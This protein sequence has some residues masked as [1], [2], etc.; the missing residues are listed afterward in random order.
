MVGVAGRR[1]LA[2]L[3]Y[4]LGENFDQYLTQATKRALQGGFGQASSAEKRAKV[5]RRKSLQGRRVSFAPDDQL[6]TIQLFQRDCD[7]PSERRLGGNQGEADPPATSIDVAEL[8]TPPAGLRQGDGAGSPMELTLSSPMAPA[9]YEQHAES[10][11]A[12]TGSSPGQDVSM[13]LT[14]GA[15]AAWRGAGQQH[16]ADLQTSG[17]V[18]AQSTFGIGPQASTN[19]GMQPSGDVS[20]ELTS[21]TGASLPAGLEEMTGQGL[22]T[23]GFTGVLA[24]GRHP[25]WG[26]QTE[27]TAMQPAMA[28]DG[29]P[30]GQVGKWGFAPG[31]DD[32]MEMNLEGKGRDLMGDT[33]FGHVFGGYEST[34]NTMG[35]R[36]SSQ[37]FIPAT[38]QPAQSATHPAAVALTPPA[39]H[40]SAHSALP[41]PGHSTHSAATSSPN[42][43]AQSRSAA[44]HSN[45]SAAGSS[46]PSAMAPSAG[47][48]TCSR[49]AWAAG[50]DE[51]QNA[52]F[53][54]GCGRPRD[55]IGAMMQQ[56]DPGRDQENV[57]GWLVD[58]PEGAAG[59]ASLIVL[60]LKSGPGTPFKERQPASL[61]DVD[62]A[63]YPSPKT[64]ADWFETPQGTA[65]PPSHPCSQTRSQSRYTLSGH[66]TCPTPRAITLQDFLQ[67]VDVQLLDHVLRGPSLAP[68]NAAL[69][70]PPRHWRYPLSHHISAPECWK[71]MCIT[72]PRM[73][74]L[75]ESCGIL[76]AEIDSKRA[77]LAQKEAD[78]ART[79][80]S[81]FL[82]LQRGSREQVETLKKCA[83]VLKRSCRKQTEGSWKRWR[84][85]LEQ[86]RQMSLQENMRTLQ[87]DA[88][89]LQVSMS[90]QQEVGARLETY[91]AESEA[92]LQAAKARKE[93]EAG[94]QARH[95]M[96]EVDILANCLGWRPET[97]SRQ[98]VGSSQQGPLE[99]PPQGFKLCFSPHLSLCVRFEAVE[100]LEAA[101]M[102]IRG[103]LLWTDSGSPSLGKALLAS[104]MGHPLAPSTKGDSSS[105]S[106]VAHSSLGAPTQ[107]LAAFELTG[108]CAPT[109]LAEK[110]REL[111]SQIQQARAVARDA[112]EL[113][114][115]VPRQYQLS[116]FAAWHGVWTKDRGPIQP[117]GSFERDQALC[118][119]PPAAG[120]AAMGVA[121]PPA[122]S[123]VGHPSPGAGPSDALQSPDAAA[124]NVFSNPLYSVA[125]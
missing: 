113:M 8:G 4:S 114:L 46:P 21:A 119:R 15:P 7:S 115:A 13:D 80:P 12:R 34:T 106:G 27:H 124:L 30:D 11:I 65:A 47:E 81:V 44:A 49:A 60:V 52:A 51:G 1:H 54:H 110:V 73:A 103:E 120:T 100:S 74:V 32:T 121:T 5:E 125:R 42:I 28:M 55:S 102:C 122:A 24:G 69:D 50:T 36:R 94:R 76:D 95:K 10:R 85:G 58:G 6:R 66:R 99:G 108:K 89:F 19:R 79:N 84:T 37:M 117:D 41:L 96:E 53:D 45:Y 67:G 64:L 56:Q 86:R 77:G 48:G 57:S 112:D 118:E 17:P 22:M 93:E 92:R 87:G 31:M 2:T 16:M 105:R 111:S 68:V 98:L 9:G 116:T 18:A 97:L 43:A 59:L 83:A 40:A 82:D 29:S 101:Q 61:P 62:P 104:L 107:P 14:L 75:E 26:S 38:L 33:T 35:V 90:H 25:A 72:V 78:L 91:I 23:P 123:T 70:P 20:M 3:K 63:R 71:L 39:A 88:A 109:A